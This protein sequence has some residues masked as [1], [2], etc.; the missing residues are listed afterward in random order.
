MKRYPRP[1]TGLFSLI[2]AFFILFNS[3]VPADE[4]AGRVLILP[5]TIHSEKDLTFLNK[6]IMEMLA[7]RISQSAEVIRGDA[8]RPGKDPV[9]TARDLDATYVVTGSLTV[10]GDSVSTDAAL[11]SVET[12][13]AALQF[14]QFGQSSSDVLMHIDQFA[15]QVSRHLASISATPAVAAPTDAAP[16]VMIPQ[17]TPKVEPVQP[18]Q[19]AAVP[20]PL[21]PTAPTTVA[22]A[23]ATPATAAPEMAANDTVEAL[24]TSSPYKGVI[25]ALTTGDVNGDGRPDIVYLHADQIVVERFDGGRLDRLALF[26]AGGSHKIL[27]VDAGDINGNQVAE[28]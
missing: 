21:Q 12:G 25:S 10:F 18:V 27:A 19:P 7:S 14:S 28:I 17:V 15:T 1:L 9:Q 26:D 24:W 5:L 20:V 16:A 8:T 11:T 3:P 6:G 13:D 2:T 4:G 23:A 22:V